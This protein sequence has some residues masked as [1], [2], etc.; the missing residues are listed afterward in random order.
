VW[1][2]IA[3]SKI[4]VSPV[5]KQLFDLGWE[6]HD[7]AGM[8]AR[9]AVKWQP[10]NLP[11][12]IA[13]TKPRS[14]DYPTGGGGGF[15]WSGVVT[16]RKKFQVP[17]DW[18]GQN[19]QLEFEGVYMNAEVSINRQLVALQPYGYSSFLVDITPYLKY[20]SEN[21]LVVVANN[22]GQPNSRWYSGTGLYR[23]VWLRV[24][25][26]VH[27][28]P[29]GVFVT[30]PVANSESSIVKVST[31]VSGAK[32][33]AAGSGKLRSTILD[34]SGAEVAQ[35]E[36]P[37]PPSVDGEVTIQQSMTVT[38]AQ[39]WSIESP[40]LYTLVSE[41]LVDG[42][43]ADT[44]KTTFGIRSF[45]LDASNGFRLNG[46]PMKLKGGCVHH[47]NG[48]LGAASYDRAEERKIELMKASGY[49]AIRCAHNPPA[50]AMLDACDRLG[51]VVIDETFDCWRM[52][53]NP[54]D[55]HLYFEDWWQRDTASM[56]LRD[57]NHPSIIMWSIGNE[58]PERTGVSDGAAWARKQAEYVRSLDPT[59]PVTSALPF[60]FE[61]IFMDPD[62]DLE[63]IASMQSLFDPENL[64]PKDPESDRWGNL[65]REFN[66]AL[67]M[68]G[69]NYL[70]SR[71]EFDGKHFPGRVMAGTETF[72]HQA[73]AYWQ[74]TERFPYVIGD[75]VWTSIDYLGESGIGKVSYGDDGMSF[76][77]AYPYHLANC[78]DI[79][80]CG[81]KRPQS[82]FRDLLWG[83]RRAPYIGVWDPQHHGKT[84]N[85]NQWGWEPVND[86]W[87]FPG[88]EGK[89]TLVDVYSADEEVELL[90]NGN[91]AGRK[92]AGAANQNKAQF[93][94]T[95]QPGTVEAVSY[96]GGQETGRAALATACAPAALRLTVDR[97]TLKLM[98]G[99]LAYVTVE[100][101]DESGAV[102]KHA[103]HTVT[104][105][106]SGAGDLLAVGTANPTSEEL[107]V[108]N[109]RNAFQGRLM[110]VVRSSG[111]AGE[112]A[113]K[114][115][116]EGLNGAE[117]TIRVK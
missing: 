54:G 106:V 73:F 43:V 71:Y 5:K 110:A 37:L 31:E 63:N 90:V 115:S 14:A 8:F 65:T 81:F 57:R 28:R 19:V 59:R 53:K 94:V 1:N 93:E 104:F 42:E 56:V 10:V 109:Q 113:L 48:L 18:R 78:G 52:G 79:D 116:A 33:V 87:D 61:E 100:V 64:R 66:E 88:W 92:P 84:A 76:G 111:E 80:I 85:F 58:V 98:F 30:T 72:P 3:T 89:P 2:S 105:D 34:G 51:M 74:E 20:G 21:E 101:V 117:V 40:N 107:Y 25:G 15:A 23:H 4:G 39:L 47:D 83:V 112:I 103:E 7:Q 26:G 102:V 77:S 99:D 97:D 11:H 75:F 108:G 24:G 49:N 70:Y 91:S 60:L 9:M 86:S 41:V 22:S 67:D 29:W 96:S 44:E 13:I 6:Y 27:I 16:Y 35:V 50:P 114:A 82:Y 32:A 12:D 46:V 62:L 95:Y 36:S 45:T 69:Y 38:S 17:E 55:Y 68:V